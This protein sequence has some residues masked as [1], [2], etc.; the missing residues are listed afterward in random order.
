MKR[1]YKATGVKVTRAGL[2]VY[3]T[4]EVGATM[5]FAA[6]VVPWSMLADCQETIVP[7]IEREVLKRLE[8]DADVLYLPLEKWE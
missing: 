7:G 2:N 1:R 4:I 6:I 8:A 3:V 5:R